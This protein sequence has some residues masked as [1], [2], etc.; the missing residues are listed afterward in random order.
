[1]E[2]QRG[3]R[4]KNKGRKT[5]KFG[6]PKYEDHPKVPTVHH[7]PAHNGSTDHLAPAFSFMHFDD[8][9]ECASTWASDEIRSLFNTLRL[10]SSRTWR[11]VH[12]SSGLN[13]KLIP[14][15]QCK[16]TLPSTISPDADLA[17]M[18]VTKKARIFG[19]RVES[20]FYVIWLDRNHAVV[21]E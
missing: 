20:V 16:R 15:G 5:A 18:R 10:A 6:I 17:E 9:V 1:M 19:A 12:A 7:G 11:D 2:S 3:M 21:P 13:F 14:P 8:R 4:Q